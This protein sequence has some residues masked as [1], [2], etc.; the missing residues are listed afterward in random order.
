ML[1]VGPGALVV[2]CD[3]YLPRPSCVMLRWTGTPRGGTSAKRIVR[4][5]WRGPG[6]PC[7]PDVER[8]RELDVADMIAAQIDVHEA[9]DQVV[10]RRV[11]V[12]VHG[13]HQG[14]GAVP[15]AD[16][17]NANFAH[18]SILCFDARSSAPSIEGLR[19]IHLQDWCHCKTRVLSMMA[20]VC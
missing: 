2:T 12:V 8:G 9:G 4:G 3:R 6:P 1:V 17:R 5:P 15:H 11:A 20:R 16:D 10:V 14:G 18:S 7:W 13:L 19:R